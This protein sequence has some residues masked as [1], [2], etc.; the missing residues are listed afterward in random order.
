MFGKVLVFLIIIFLFIVKIWV[1]VMLG[2]KNTSYK[3]IY[4]SQNLFKKPSHPLRITC[5]DLKRNVNSG[6][7]LGY[8]SRRQRW[9]L[10]AN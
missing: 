6:Y 4:N 5:K 2:E 9:G 8:S 1:T 3:T 10:K 7:L